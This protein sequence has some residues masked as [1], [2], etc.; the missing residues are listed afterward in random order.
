MFSDLRI[1]LIAPVWYLYL[2]G[3]HWPSSCT[4]QWLTWYSEAF[5][6]ACTHPQQSLYCVF[7]V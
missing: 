1:C 3:T 2:S 5:K 7:L 4:M 6:K